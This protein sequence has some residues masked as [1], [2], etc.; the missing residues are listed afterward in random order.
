MSNSITI[1]TIPLSVSYKEVVLLSKS[2]PVLIKAVKKYVCELKDV[3]V[4]EHFDNIIATNKGYY[5][6]FYS[7]ELQ[8]VSP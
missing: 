5:C 1:A 7:N 6:A 8:K 4:F 3:E 2:D